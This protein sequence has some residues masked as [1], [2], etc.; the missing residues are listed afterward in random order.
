MSTEITGISRPTEN[1]LISI[2]KRA[3]TEIDNLKSS[4]QRLSDKMEMVE[5][6]QTALF[7]QPV[8]RSQGYGEDVAWLIDRALKRLETP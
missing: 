3:K 6:F 1:D 4:N 8:G 7:T 2:L 5:L